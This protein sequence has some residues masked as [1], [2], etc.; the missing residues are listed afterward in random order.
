MRK[1]I[2]TYLEST[3][4]RREHETYG[5]W[6]YDN[7]WHIARDKRWRGQLTLCGL[8]VGTYALNYNDVSRVNCQKC[9]D[10]FKKGKR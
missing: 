2:L 3:N 6:I 5:D 1:Q 8:V 9:M 10:K 7:T 4:R